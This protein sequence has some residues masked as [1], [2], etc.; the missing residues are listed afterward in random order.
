MNHKQFLIRDANSSDISTFM[1]LI[2]LKAEFDGCLDFL[3]ATPKKLEDTLF[4]ENPLAFVLL[5]EIDGNPIGFATYHRIYST[6]LAQPG[7]WLDDLYIKAE[8]R[9][10]GIGEALIKRLCQITQKI[11]GGRIDW[12]VAVNNTPAIQFYEKMGAKIIQKSRFCRLDREEIK[13]KT[14]P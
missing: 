3:E 7:I 1:E 11:E 2:R 9:R 5:A 12:I 10:L 4:C 14:A 6:F 13:Q 8:Y